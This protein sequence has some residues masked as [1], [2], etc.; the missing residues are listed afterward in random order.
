M[1]GEWIPIIGFL[2]LT[3]VMSLFFWF[4]HKT[5]AEMQATIRTALDK[6][7]ELSPEI[8]DRLGTPKPA[9]DKDLR[10]AL[11]WFALALSTAAFGY[12]F[13]D[14]EPEVMQVFLGISAFPMSLGIAYLIM[15]FNSGRNS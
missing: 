8:I 13:P 1:Q 9:K 5:R 11:I 3:A 14:D 12:A 2:G 4:R 15:W 7:Q 10:A 6:G